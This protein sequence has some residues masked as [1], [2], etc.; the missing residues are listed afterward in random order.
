MKLKSF[1]EEEITRRESLLK[2]EEHKKRILSEAIDI[3]LPGKFNSLSA[4]NIPS[5]ESSRR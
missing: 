4:G 3:T 2:K 5:A 1:V